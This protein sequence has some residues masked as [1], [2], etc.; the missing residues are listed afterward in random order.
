LGREIDRNP[1]PGLIR[2][3]SRLRQERTATIHRFSNT[4]L[5]R[6]PAAPAPNTNSGGGHV[7]AVVVV[8]IVVVA[9][10]LL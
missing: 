2:R 4:R 6:I 10:A 9:R 7:L 1:S 3:A 5:S 8:V